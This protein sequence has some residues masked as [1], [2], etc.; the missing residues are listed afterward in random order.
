MDR[1]DKQGE[2]MFSL[3]GRNLDHD[4]DEQVV[5]WAIFQFQEE[6]ILWW[7]VFNALDSCWRL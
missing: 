2:M 1:I 7:E 5:E 4:L 6:S 3:S